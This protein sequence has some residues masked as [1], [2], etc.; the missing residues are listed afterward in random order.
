M[1]NNKDCSKEYR[2]THL[3][4]SHHPGSPKEESPL[5]DPYLD[6]DGF[7][8]LN[9]RKV[10]VVLGWQ[11]LLEISPVGCWGKLFIERCLIGNPLL[12][13]CLRWVLGE[14]SGNWLLLATWSTASRSCRNCTRCWSLVLER[15]CQRSL[16]GLLTRIRSKALFLLC[17]LLSILDEQS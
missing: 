3:R 13:N 10:I 16:S 7:G 17:C 5:Y 12:K 11:N 15:A 2:K 8:S 9:S 4:N 1:F 14:A 6:G